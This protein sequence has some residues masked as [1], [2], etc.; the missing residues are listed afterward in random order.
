M[1]ELEQVIALGDLALHLLH[2]QEDAHEP[3]KLRVACVEGAPEHAP[4]GP[5]LCHG[6]VRLERF[7]LHNLGRLVPGCHAVRALPGVQPVLRGLGESEAVQVAVRLCS[8]LCGSR[9]LW[10]GIV[11]LVHSRARQPVGKRHA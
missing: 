1:D 8:V 11:A 6:A 4:T 2:K 9:H 5:A 10:G 7:Q 3:L